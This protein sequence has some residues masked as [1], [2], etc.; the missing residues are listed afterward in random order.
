MSKNYKLVNFRLKK[1]SIFGPKNVHKTD[2]SEIEKFK[3]TFNYEN[4]KRIQEIKVLE[5]DIEKNKNEFDTRVNDVQSLCTLLE[6]KINNNKSVL[7]IVAESKGSLTK[8]E[9]FSFGNGGKEKDVGYRVMYPMRVLGIGISSERTAGEINI[10]VVVNGAEMPGCDI[11]V[12]ANRKNYDRIYDFY[13]ELLP[14]KII[15]FINKKNNP[16]AVNTVVSL[17]M[18][19]T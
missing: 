18:Q 1:M 12:P 13:F 5:K 4:V 17:I 19:L 14:G 16:T 6:M 15:N 10:G 2:N 8:G 3:N 7:T 9:V 11:T